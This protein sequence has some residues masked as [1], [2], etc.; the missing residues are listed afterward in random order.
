MF[1]L[2]FNCHS[3]TLF[4]GSIACFFR[5]TLQQELSAVL[6]YVVLVAFGRYWLQP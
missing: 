1:R 2:K 6:L 4:N 5:L 3:S